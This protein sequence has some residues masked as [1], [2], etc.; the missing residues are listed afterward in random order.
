MLSDENRRMPFRERQN[1]IKFATMSLM[2]YTPQPEILAKYARVLTEYALGN[3]EGIKKGDVVYI[4][5]DAEALPLALATYKHVLE[6]GAH[7]IVKQNEE[8]FGR[9]FMNE[10]SNDQLEFYPEKY[11]KSLIDS[12]DHRM[13]LIAPRDPF[14]LKDADPA[15]VMRAQKN[16][17]EMRKY[18]TQKQDAGDLTWTLCLYGT[19]GLAKEAGTSVE[20]FWQQITEACFLDEADP[21][22]TWKKVSGEIIAVRDTLSAMPIDT[23][24]VTAEGTDLTLKL[25][26]GRKWLAGSGNNIPSFE[27]FTSPDWR[28]TEGH[29][30]FDYP[31][32]RY[33]N[34]IKDIRLEFKEGKVVKATASQNEK[35]IQELVKQENA[36]KVGEYSLTD[37]KFSRINRFMA[38]TL[39]DENYGGKWGNTH[40][41][42]GMSFHDAYTGDVKGMKDEDWDKLGF[43]ES[44]EHTDIM[45]ISD[46]TVEATMKDGSKKVI[47]K[48]GHFVV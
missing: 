21:V 42:L 5:Y 35:L 27:I 22:A 9:I 19:E 18:I 17:K 44:P 46:R 25:G 4:N 29:I 15:K 11:F 31:L 20:E 1:T 10:A 36:D 13:Y 41:A 30:T 39:Y 28:G 43:N 8:E 2:S 33:G 23:L 16:M 7:P 24:H 34:L 48:G 12:I 14:Y 26:E 37:T 6:L 32:Y 40:V 38:N 47:Y 45:A 3:E